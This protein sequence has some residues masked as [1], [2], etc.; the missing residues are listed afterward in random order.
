MK[1]T[2]LRVLCLLLS[3]AMLLTMLPM[4]VWAKDDVYDEIEDIISDS[5]PTTVMSK[6]NSK[7]EAED[8]LSGKWWY[9]LKKDLADELDE[10]DLNPSRLNFYLDDFEKAIPKNRY[11]TDGTIGS[12]IVVVTYRGKMLGHTTLVIEPDVWGRVPDDNDD[13]DDVSFYGDDDLAVKVYWEGDTAASRPDSLTLR[14]YKDGKLYRTRSI[15]GSKWYEAWDDVEESK[16][17]TVDVTVPDGYK[18]NIEKVEDDYFEI[19]MTKVGGSIV[20]PSTPSSSPSTDKVN[21][22]TGAF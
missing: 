1:K 9:S 2:K 12:A 20:T 6:V 4:A 5:V 22:S 3:L 21:P 14:L 13:D 16:K 7:S 10:A 11:D 8:W 18:C 19:T 15:S 17:W